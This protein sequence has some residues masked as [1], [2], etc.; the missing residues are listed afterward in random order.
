MVEYKSLLQGIGEHN[1][2]QVDEGKLH[3][4]ARAQQDHGSR[5]GVLGVSSQQR[6][7]RAR[8]DKILFDPI[9]LDL[10]WRIDRNYL[11]VRII[12]QT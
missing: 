8:Q 12:F 11:D 6:C 10:I 2:E 9:K 3:G 5:W 4:D 1:G 7:A